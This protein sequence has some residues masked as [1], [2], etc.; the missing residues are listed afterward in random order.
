MV[1]LQDCGVDNLKGATADRQCRHAL[2]QGRFVSWA[3]HW[4]PGAQNFSGVPW[5]FNNAPVQL[6]GHYDGLLVCEMTLAHQCCH[7]L[8]EAVHCLRL[9]GVSTLCWCVALSQPCRSFVAAAR[10]EHAHRGPATPTLP[11]S[12]SASSRALSQLR[13]RLIKDDVSDCSNDAV[14]RFALQGPFEVHYCQP[15]PRFRPVAAHALQREQ[16]D[17]AAPRFS[18]CTMPVVFWPFW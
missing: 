14:R 3:P 15:Q 13:Q 12:F 10:S 4:Q 7:A 18:R 2:I 8:D 16:P 17:I 1:L 9:L 5:R 6:P 11:P